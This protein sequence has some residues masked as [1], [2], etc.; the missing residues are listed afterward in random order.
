MAPFAQPVPRR[1]ERRIAKIAIIMFVETERK[2]EECDA[3]TL[4]FSA[5]GAR[6]EVGTSLTP[7]QVV[8]VDPGDG[9]DRVT[10]RVVWVGKPASDMEG[11]AGLEFF[12]PL[13]WINIKHGRT[14]GSF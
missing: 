7:G 12:D 8:E 14:P 4:D 3:V 9:S 6:I 11:Q 5:Y 2:W 10:G 13:P 1:S